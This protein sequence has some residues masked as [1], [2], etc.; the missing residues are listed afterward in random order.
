MIQWARAA[1]LLAIRQG[2][3]HGMRVGNKGRW[4]NGRGGRARDRMG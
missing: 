4:E 3:K 1:G 2:Y